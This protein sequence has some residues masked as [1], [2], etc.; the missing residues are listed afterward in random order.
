MAYIY[1][2]HCDEGLPVPTIRQVLT[3]N[4]RCPHCGL[5][6]YDRLSAEET[7]EAMGE[8]LDRLEALE[9]KK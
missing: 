8:L 4:Y 6:N 1:C 7:A 3:N 2:D 9:A 5:N